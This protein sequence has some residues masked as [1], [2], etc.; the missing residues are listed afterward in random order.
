[1]NFNFEYS[2]ETAWIDLLDAYIC[3]ELSKTRESLL[4]VGTYLGGFVFSISSNNSSIRIT[5]VDPYPTIKNIKATF[6]GK[7][8]SKIR[9]ENWVGLF[10]RIE[11]IPTG[12]RFDFIHIDGEHSEE[13]VENDLIQSYKYAKTSENIVIVV[14]DIFMRHFPGVTSGAL[15]FA[16]ENNFAPFLL[17]G[18]KM[19]FCKPSHHEKLLSE[20]TSILLA[21]G[22]EFRTDQARDKEVINGFI[23][24]NKV[25]KHSMIV[26]S[27]N[28]S[29]NELE[30]YLKVKKRPLKLRGFLKMVIP[31]YVI[32]LYRRIRQH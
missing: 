29:L 24:S 17:T 3:T 20:I 22:V 31:P 28:F 18:K 13:A 1:V 12:S 26:I 7:V 2:I 8:K 15:K 6:L 21:A 23:Q 19:Y 4:E 16:F 25:L 32:M 5:C 14:D 27:N 11:D 30:K 9:S 10:D